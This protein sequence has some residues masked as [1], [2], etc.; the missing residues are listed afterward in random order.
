MPKVADIKIATFLKFQKILIL[1]ETMVLIFLLH[2]RVYS[3]NSQ[4]G[5]IISLIIKF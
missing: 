2:I 4:N 3:F 5:S 1:P